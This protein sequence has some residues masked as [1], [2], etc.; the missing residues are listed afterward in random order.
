MENQSSQIPPAGPAGAAAQVD[1]GLVEQ[2]LKLSNQLKSGAGWFYW[3]AGLSLVNTVIFIF[4][5]QWNFIMGLGLTQVVDAIAKEA[6]GG[7]A[8]KG[9]AVVIDLIIAGMFVGFGVM[10]SKRQNWAFI[11]GMIIYALDALIFIMAKDFL[12]IA[13][14]GLALWFIFGGMKAGRKLAELEKSTPVK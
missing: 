14:H 3:I 4:G 7:M 1:S 8:I 12:G 13:F 5:G 2:K 11:T 6:G 10:A 9:I